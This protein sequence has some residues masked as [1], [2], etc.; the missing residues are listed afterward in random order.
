MEFTTK[1]KIGGGLVLLFSVLLGIVLISLVSFSNAQQKLQRV[2]EQYQ[3]K[4]LTAMQLTT[5]F[6]HSLSVLGNYLIEQDDYNMQL[7]NQKVTDIDTT[8]DELKRL[9][10]VYIDETQGHQV[11]EIY[12]LVE[13]IK[14]ANGMLLLLANEISKNIPAIGL[15]QEELEPQ[16][17]KM[18][19]LITDLLVLAE[20]NEQPILIQQIMNLRFNWTMVSGQLSKFFAFRKKETLSEINL[21]TEGVEQSV[22]ALQ[23]SEIKNDEEQQEL[24]DEIIIVWNKYLNIRQN[25]LTIHSSKE[26]R[27]D[28]VLM[29]QDI[30]PSLRELTIK[31]EGLV[32]KQQRRIK[33]SNMELSQVINNAENTIQT[34]I[35]IAIVVAIGV[36][37]L[38]FRNSN[39]H[40]EII[41]R[42]K[43]EARM[44]HKATHDALTGIPNRLLFQERVNAA[45]SNLTA[46]G[47]EHAVLFI[48][49]DGFKQV[50]DTFGHDAG[51]AILIESASRLLSLVR[52]SDTLARIGGDEFTVLLFGIRSKDVATNIASKMCDLISRPI[53]FKKQQLTVGCSIGISFYSDI[54]T[55]T[56]DNL[57]KGELFIKRADEAMYQAKDAGKN[58]YRTYTVSKEK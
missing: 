22:S 26:W 16:S 32:T 19:Q 44:R 47:D 6:Y 57:N 35:K 30:S 10:S 50:N 28:R 7:Y 52:N 23:K 12:T 17:V 36:M 54:D 58:T 3:P 4:M 11:D 37:I 13:K 55:G 29:R 9:A 46:K 40:T 39:L 41:Y 31:L 42:K 8:L 20:E 25:A 18:Y 1:Q 49:L 34:I 33:D 27:K 21:Y 53:D 24:L 48:D 38:Y 43:N 15:A 45:V 14:D 56:D 2:T 51:D 5:H